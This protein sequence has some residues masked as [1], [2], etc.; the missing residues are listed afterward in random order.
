MSTSP[1]QRVTIADVARYAGVSTATVSRV[2]NGQGVVSPHT[3]TRVEAAI[4][5]L[6]F[7]P[8]MGASELAGRR[9]NTI[10]LIFPGIGDPFLAASLQG[11]EDVIAAA[12]FEL[13]LHVGR[14]RREQRYYLP[15]GEHN[16]D[17]IIVFGDGLHPQEIQRFHA[18]G[19]PLVLLHGR[20]PEG[21]AIPAVAFANEAGARAMVDHLVA[22]GHRRIA[23]L[24]GPTGNA[25]AAQRAQGFQAGMAAHELVIAPTL[26]ADGGFDAEC[27][28]DAVANWLVQ[29]VEMDAIFA[30]DDTSARGAI[31]ALQQA[32]LRVPADIAVVG[33]DD[34]RFAR[35]MTPPLTTVRA[36]IE[37]AGRI[38]AAQLLMRIESGRTEDETA[39]SL[40][41]LPTELV[42]RQS[43]GWSE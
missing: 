28:A 7:A 32:G 2:I 29:D 34:D 37:E 17:G 8:H 26:I 21:L 9:P 38:A 42:V 19:F 40:T 3:V 11:I 14:T 35:Y 1:T 5:A 31:F 6:D 39:P 25:D 23:F 20:P 4:A 24:R 43:C 12:G 16:A 41:L 10:G 27:A 13:L 15:I 22:C 30:A 33:F 18:R 36:P